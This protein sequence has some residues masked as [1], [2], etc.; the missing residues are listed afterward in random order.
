MATQGTIVRN[1]ARQ[2]EKIRSAEE[3]YSRLIIN[4]SL[5]GA[6]IVIV[7]IAVVV[8]GL[9]ISR[10]IMV[11]KSWL[12]IGVPLGLVGLGFVVFPKT[13]EWE[14]KPWQAKP[15]QYEKHIIG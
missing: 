10:E 9:I 11:G 2:V 15:E 7:A 5:Q 8:F 12:S 6:L 13:E 14:Y 3:F 4:R 1:N